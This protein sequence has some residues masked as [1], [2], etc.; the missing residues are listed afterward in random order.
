MGAGYSVQRRSHEFTEHVKTLMGG[1]PS[2]KS[3]GKL[4]FCNLDVFSYDLQIGHIHLDDQVIVYSGEPNTKTT[5]HHISAI[6]HSEWRLP[7][8][9]FLAVENDHINDSLEQHVMRWGCKNPNKQD[10]MDCL[11][12]WRFIKSEKRKD[13]LICEYAQADQQKRDNMRG[14]IEMA[15]EGEL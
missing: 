2:V 4:V 9:M 11:D 13:S 6:S 7:K 14:L 8:W 1:E 5:N 10:I 15:R 12:F 3:F